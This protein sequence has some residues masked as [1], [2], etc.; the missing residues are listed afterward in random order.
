MADLNG[1]DFRAVTRISNKANETLAN[2]GETCALVSADSLEWLLECGAIERIEPAA[3]VVA[4]EVEV[5]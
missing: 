2:P 1:Q 3:A 5:A 4:P